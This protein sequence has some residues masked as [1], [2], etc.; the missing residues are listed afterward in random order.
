VETRRIEIRGV[1]APGNMAYDDEDG[2]A[3]EDEE[4]DDEGGEEK[5]GRSWSKTMSWKGTK[6]LLTTGK[7]PKEGETYSSGAPL[8]KS[9][10]TGGF[11][12]S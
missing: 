9:V 7:L 6:S 12:G 8:K 1:A 2:M 11:I 5:R 10:S 4:D 3:V